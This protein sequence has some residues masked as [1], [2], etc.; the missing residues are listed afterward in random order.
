MKKR[1][2][3]KIM[4]LI[5]V[6]VVF[7]TLVACNPENVVFLGKYFN[8]ADSLSY[9]NVTSSSQ[10]TL[11]SVKV[12]CCKTSKS[13]SVTIT[14]NQDKAEVYFDCPTCSKTN[15]ANVI[16][17]RTFTHYNATYVR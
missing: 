7:L 1:I 8:T 15:I 6:S 4:A 10:A 17:E 2:F 9:V 11:C 14:A 5:I 16:D 3:K 12:S 13:A